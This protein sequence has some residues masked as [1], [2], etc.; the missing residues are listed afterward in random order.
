MDGQRIKKAAP[1]RS[2]RERLV[3]AQSSGA[4][5][6]QTRLGSPPMRTRFIS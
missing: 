1:V 6:S 2:G 5:L 3:S 4:F